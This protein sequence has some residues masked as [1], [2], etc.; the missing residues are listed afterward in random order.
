VLAVTLEAFGDDE[1]PG[2]EEE[3]GI[4]APRTLALLGIA[5]ACCTLLLAGMPPFSGF[6]AKFAI[7]DAVLNLGGLGTS[8]AI[9]APSW[10]L[11]SL[12]IVSG[13]AAMIALLRAGINTFWVTFD[14]EVPRVRVVEMLPILLLL[15]LCLALTVL[16]GPAMGYM[17]ATAHD[18]HMPGD[19]LGSVLGGGNGGKLQ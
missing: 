11:V 5:F 13:L 7:I 1:E 16:A 19:Y 9:S 18:L 6:L 10:W 14:G 2:H 8:P 4:A 17:Q 12:L 15:G 3:V